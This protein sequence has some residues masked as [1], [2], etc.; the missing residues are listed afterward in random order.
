MADP[1]LGEIRMFAGN[2]APYQWCFC[3]GQLLP[4]V[5]NDAL[6]SLLG[7]SYGGDGHSTFGLPDMRGRL[8]VHFG[9]GTNLTPRQIGARSGSETASLSVQQMPSHRHS[10]HASNNVVTNAQPTN[11][12]PAVATEPF[13]YADPS[14]TTVVSFPDS[15]ME[16]SGN[17][18]PHSNLMPFRVVNFIMALKGLY[19]PRN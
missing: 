16:S 17:N 14:G 8:P 1:F 2:F 13:Y 11:L 7:T 10:I 19:P 4:I 6:F 12:V 15:V 18:V 9:S 3:D 5:G